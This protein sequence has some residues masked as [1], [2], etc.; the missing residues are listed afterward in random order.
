MSWD[1]ICYM[2]SS[3][4][5]TVIRMAVPPNGNDCTLPAASAMKGRIATAPRNRAPGRVIL[6][7]M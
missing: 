3:P 2:V 6:V 5:P 1:S 4:T 7:R